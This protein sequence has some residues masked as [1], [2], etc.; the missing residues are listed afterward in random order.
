MEKCKICLCSNTITITAA[1]ERAMQNPESVE[2]C[3]GTHLCRTGQAG[4][5]FIV[6]ESGVAAG[7]RRIE[8]VTGWNAYAQAVE[9]RTTLL[10]LANA[11]KTRPG[12]LAERVNALQEEV[13]KLRKAAEKTSTSGAELASQAEDVHGL[14]VLTASLN[15]G[16]IKALRE[17]MDDVRSRLDSQAVACLATTEGNKVGLLLYVSKDLHSR[18][19]APALIKDVAAACGGSGGGRPDLAQAGGTKPEGI[20]AAFALLKKCLGQ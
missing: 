14:R 13:K 3:G 15:G 17:V 16:P 4:N 19:T 1:F 18:F 20:G 9:Q 11:L 8:A 12:Q 6:A 5:F 2:L 10:D 7:T